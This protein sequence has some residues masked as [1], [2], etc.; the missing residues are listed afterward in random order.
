M[1]PFLGG[2]LFSQT[3]Y[4]WREFEGTGLLEK[5]LLIESV[6]NYVGGGFDFYKN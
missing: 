5:N 1:I 3:H 6:F 2:T 4:Y